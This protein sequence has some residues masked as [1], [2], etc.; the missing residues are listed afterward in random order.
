MKRGPTRLAAR[1]LQRLLKPYAA[2]RASFH[3]STLEDPVISAIA[4]SHGK[5]RPR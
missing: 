4:E 5:S 2:A 1:R 3:G